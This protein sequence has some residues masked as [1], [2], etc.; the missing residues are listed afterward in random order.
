MRFCT[1]VSVGMQLQ[2]QQEEKGIT[3]MAIALRTNK[4]VL[5]ALIIVAIL[6]FIALTFTVL[7]VEHINLWQDAIKFVPAASF[8][9]M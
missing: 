1:L 4:Q 2:Q 6:T 7:S 9:N 8:G 3:H 5:A